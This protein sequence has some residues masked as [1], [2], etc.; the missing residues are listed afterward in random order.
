MKWLYNKLKLICFGFICIT[1]A[2]A[3]FLAAVSLY[4]CLECWLDKKQIKEYNKQ[5]KSLAKKLNFADFDTHER[6][7]IIRVRGKPRMAVVFSTGL[8]F[9]RIYQDV[10]IVMDNGRYGHFYK[11]EDYDSCRLSS[12]AEL[13]GLLS[14][15]LGDLEQEIKLATGKVKA[16]RYTECTPQFLEGQS[17][18]YDEIM[19][20]SSFMKKRGYEEVIETDA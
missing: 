20:L 13:Y 12:N 16:I 11:E 9:G 8:S 3:I 17:R 6:I 7:T 4:E 18:L 1:A 14:S 5:M 10:I 19:D 15:C 2:M